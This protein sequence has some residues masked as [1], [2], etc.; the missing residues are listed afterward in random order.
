M[1]DRISASTSRAVR[2]NSK[3]ACLR[4]SFLAVFCIPAL[5]LAAPAQAASAGS[6][7]PISDFMTMDVCIGQNGAVLPGVIPGSAACKSHRDIRP[8]EQ[9]PYIIGNFPAPKAKCDASP[10]SKINVPI[11]RGDVT[12]ITSTTVRSGCG[13]AGGPA[14]DDD[15]ND[16]GAS[17]QWYD[18][19]YGF[20]MGSYSP[21]ALSSFE[22]DNCA[23][24]PASSERFFRGWV[25]APAA[26][27]AIGETGYGAFP[28]KL[29]KGKPSDLPSACSVRYN[30]GLT[31][32]TVD[33][34]RFKSDRQL[35]S[36]ISGHFSRSSQKRN[37]PGEA[38][39]LEQTYW[40]REFGL[41]RWE[42]WAREDWVHPRW[43]KSARELAQQLVAAGRCSRPALKV[44]SYSPN[45]QV[46]ALLSDES[47]YS[48]VIVDPQTGEKHTWYMT[49]CED[50]TNAVPA[51]QSV[52]YIK[53][54]DSL[55]DDLYWR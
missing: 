46:S 36:I 21:V 28:S 48:R 16:G 26:V 29:H 11:R 38:M 8:G 47:A 14:D 5:A 19:G 39:Q 4:A 54:I 37:A 24:N 27:P 17:I 35:L 32:W 25:I 18:R 13:S 1:I 53:P 15:L 3:A 31:T 45:L 42:K 55:A 23:Q 12:R 9:P 40:T 50:Y 41:S 33:N 51:A 2:F 44:A 7:G 22:S 49:L 43:K 52:D 34:F 20:I 10:V 6:S 30:R